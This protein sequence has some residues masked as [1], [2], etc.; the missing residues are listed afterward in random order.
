MENKKQQLERIMDLVGMS[1]NKTIK[2]I[3]QLERMNNDISEKISEQK[4]AIQ[5]LEMAMYQ[6]RKLREEDENENNQ[7]K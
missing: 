4:K 5:T 6:L 1:L 3:E 7:S 2:T